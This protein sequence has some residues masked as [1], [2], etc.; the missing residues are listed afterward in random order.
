MMNCIWV[1]KRAKGHRLGH[2]LMDYMMNYEREAT[3]FSTIVLEGHWSGWLRRGQMKWLG[4][5]AIDSVK[6]RYRTR[7]REI[8]FK[9][10]LMW[11]SRREGAEPQ[12]W[13]V[14]R[15]LEG[16]NFCLTHPL[17]H[18]ETLRGMRKIYERC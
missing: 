12:R 16:M 7:H 10:Y 9:V 14:E 11:L 5:R 15:L 2:L 18:S 3:G 4:F 1:L 17:Y 8:C 13:D 6:M